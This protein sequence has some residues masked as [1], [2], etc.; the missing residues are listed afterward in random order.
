[1]P[2][3][4]PDGVSPN[5]DGLNDDFDIPGLHDVF[6]NMEVKIFNRYGVQI[7]EGDSELRWD[8]RANR[9]INNKG[10][11]LPIGTYFYVIY[12]NDPN[13]KEPITGWVYLN[14]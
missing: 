10:E 6:E 13:F 7:F 4:I 12:L 9:G 1:M 14:Y 2:D 11:L 3:V 5:D 8:G